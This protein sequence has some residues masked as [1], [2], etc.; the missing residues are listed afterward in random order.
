[1]F[2]FDS[3]VVVV[4]MRGLNTGYFCKHGDGASET[5]TMKK[6]QKKQKKQE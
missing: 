1:M 2:F 3:S 4:A 6:K 5:A